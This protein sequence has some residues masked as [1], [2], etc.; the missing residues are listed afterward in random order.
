M[1]RWDARRTEH[2][3]RGRD[4]GRPESDIDPEQGPVQRFA[5][6]LR[7]LRQKAGGITY[8]QMARQVEVSVSTLSRAAGGE[9][10]PS[11]SV[12]L[13]YVRACGGDEEEWQ[14]RWREAVTERARA[15]TPLVDETVSA[16]YRGLTRFDVGD[17]ELFFGRDEVAN[18]LARAVTEHRVVALFGPSGSGKSSLLRA[19]LAPRLRSLQG[20]NRPAALRI[21]S[22]GEHPLRT[23][24]A[25]CVPAPGQGDTWLVVDQFEEVFTLCHDPDERAGFIARLLAATEP[26][27]RLRVVLGV[28]ADFYGHCLSHPELATAIRESTVPVGPMDADALRAVIIKPAQ[29]RGLIVERAL[30]TRLTEEAAGEPGGLP[31]LSHV[32]LETW[33]RSRGRTLTVAAYEAA[34]GL[35]GAI[36]QTAET[37]HAQLTSTQA[38]LARLLLLR[39]ITPGEGVPDTRRPAPR[40][41]L[42]LAE[43]SGDVNQVLDRLARARLIT[44]DN[45]TVDLAHEA[46]IIGWPRLRG[47]IDED[48]ERLRCHRRLTEA[49]QAWQELGHDPGALYRGTRLATAHEY[50]PQAHDHPDLND[51]E[52]EFLTASTTARDREAHAADRITRRLRRLTAALS[53]LL[54]LAVAAGLVAWHQSRTSNQQRT[55]AVA[56][57]QT[58]VSRQLAAQSSA[59][60]DTN[61]DLASLLA[62]HA[63]RT[64]PTT[65][66]TAS[67]YAAA[68]LPL[69]YRLSG[70][71]HV[72]SPDGLTLASV[73]DSQA[74]QLRDVASG[75]IRHTL[76]ELD[77][78]DVT[79]VFSP[80]SHTLAT[81]AEDG[82]VRL[83][84][85]ANGTLRRTLSGRDDPVARIAFTPNGRAIAVGSGDGSV[86]LW[87]VATGRLRHTITAHTNNVEAVVFSPDGR[88]LATSSVGRSVRLW[89]TATGKPLRTLRTRA[90]PY[91]AVAFS[92]DGRTLAT[93]GEDNGA[94]RLW[95]MASDKSRRILTDHTGSVTAV[96]FSADGRTLATGGSDRS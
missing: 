71:A 69:K 63:Y 94:V 36:A 26:G 5:G 1:R 32:L 77:E 49:A 90:A 30:T 10:L 85:A 23:H 35:H 42:D 57:Q 8:R 38:D 76:A 46:L 22:P 78:P 83:W 7:E 79:V 73:T 59:L 15:S 19:G 45:G 60:L 93:G 53:L 68:D 95:D 89:D 65:E 6:E 43:D 16:P 72:L 75:K 56:A 2:S 88:T 54:V 67:L 41:E 9:Q 80:D 37:I 55:R 28:R 17:E 14:A 25:V 74:V 64:A 70:S 34:G 50:F 51:V 18:A 48:R 40:P 4:V 82:T 91:T 58:A 96:V 13:A 92:P 31:L 33:R 12:A 3:E 24:D 27:S 61:S 20:P 84:D 66:A 47:W 44:L 21:L 39:L 11:L 86:S 52:R 62:I 87:D 81:G 29:A